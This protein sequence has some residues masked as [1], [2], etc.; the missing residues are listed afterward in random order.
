MP[1]FV[2]LERAH[3][4]VGTTIAGK[5][6]LDRLLG[7][8]GMASVYAATHRNNKRVAVKVLHAELSVHADLRL[9]FMRE[10]YVAN[11]V[12]HP[13]A[14]AVLDDDVTEDGAAFLV[15]ELLDGAT[16]ADAADRMG[17][18][19]PLRAVLAVADQVLDVLAAADAHNIV[20]RDIKPANL[21]LTTAGLVKVL[22]FG[23]ARMRDVQGPHTTHSGVALGT[24]A[25]MA[26]EQAIGRTE[27]VG[28]RTDLWAL[29]ATI[30]ALLTGRAVH[31][32]SSGQQQ[33]V[34]A[35]TRSANSLATIDPAVPAPVVA[36]VDRALAF[37]PHARWENAMAMRRALR[38]AYRAI[39]DED[40]APASLVALAASVRGESSVSSAPNAP[41]PLAH[42]QTP[43]AMAPTFPA[44]PVDSGGRARPSGRESS[45]SGRT[46]AVSLAGT[47]SQPRVSPTSRARAAVGATVLVVCGGLLGAWALGRSS[48]TSSVPVSTST[49]ATGS[50]PTAA[51]LPSLWVGSASAAPSA[52]AASSVSSAALPSASAAANAPEPV[53]PSPTSPIRSRSGVQVD[54]A[55]PRSKTPQAPA[56]AVSHSPT[57]HDEFDHQ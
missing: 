4:R 43:N 44:T 41:S 56:P 15:M 29:G 48:R 22:D 26:P 51:T 6:R 19:L 57:P 21:F 32:A 36:M 33:M 24:P 30:F 28:G 55:S 16:L 35:A 47:M 53:R 10:G 49:A 3:A 54:V 1:E 14:V 46:P 23:V 2:A 17:G 7:V 11:T 12:D 13:G 42:T 39:F 38:E 52:S 20:H 34:Y 25:F 18:R 45:G 31:E 5:Y 27:D 9:R 37:H 40:P 50:V 8:G